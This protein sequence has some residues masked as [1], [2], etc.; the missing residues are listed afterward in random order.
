M[1]SV[2]SPIR[3]RREKVLA[4]IEGRGW[5][6]KNV[7]RAVGVSEA[8]VSRVLR[9]VQNPGPKFI[10]GWM[11]MLGEGASFEEFFLL[12]SSDTLR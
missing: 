2:L 7:A 9:E 5:C 3:L 4:Y 10:A 11:R 8:Q 12:D 1:D 6:M